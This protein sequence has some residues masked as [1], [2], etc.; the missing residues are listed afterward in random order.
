MDARDAQLAEPNST[1]KD[2]QLS[3]A[4]T[5]ENVL[6]SKWDKYMKASSPFHDFDSFQEC[7]ESVEK[8][9]SAFR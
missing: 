8:Y 3:G 9:R 2:W 4:Q 5:N 1:H 6:I 7:L